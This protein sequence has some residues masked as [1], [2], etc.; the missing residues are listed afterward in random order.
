MFVADVQPA[1]VPRS[2]FVV[3]VRKVLVAE[4]KRVPK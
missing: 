3:M 2:S 4:R 1:L